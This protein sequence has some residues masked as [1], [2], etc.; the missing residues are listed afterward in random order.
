VQRAQQD[1]DRARNEA[2]AY[3][4]KVVPEAR[5]E[6]A[7]LIQQ[8]EAYKER[9][10]K[11]SEGEAQRFVLVYDEYA[12]APELTRQ[13]IYI[14]TLQ[15]VLASTQKMILDPTLQGTVPYLPLNELRPKT[16]Q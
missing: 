1:R 5:G 11:E 10:I 2:E 16:T 13:R 15:E 7:Q 4:N 8:A 3:R 9:V 14:E 12:K 6:A